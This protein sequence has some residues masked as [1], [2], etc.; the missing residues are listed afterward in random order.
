MQGVSKD[1]NNNNNSS[2]KSILEDKTRIGIKSLTT[3]ITI[4]ELCR[5]YNLNQN[6]FYNWK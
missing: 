1:N 5:K 6:V 2:R 3:N 4:A